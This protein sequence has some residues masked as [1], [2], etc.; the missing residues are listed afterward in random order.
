MGSQNEAAADTVHEHLRI[1]SVTVH[2]TVFNVPQSE[3]LHQYTS[4]HIGALAV[5]GHGLQLV[6]NLMGELVA[7][8]APAFLSLFRTFLFHLTIVY[9][10][11]HIRLF[12]IPCPQYCPYPC[13]KRNL[14]SPPHPP[15]GPRNIRPQTGRWRSRREGTE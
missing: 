13:L 9:D 1:L 5:A 3:L 7:E 10:L 12:L 8:L 2:D 15:P 4:Y 11:C 6:R 14:W